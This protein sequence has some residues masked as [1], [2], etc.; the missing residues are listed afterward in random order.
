MNNDEQDDLTNPSGGIS[1]VS[2]VLFADSWRIHPYCPDSSEIK[3]S[4]NF[5]FLIILIV[6]LLLRLVE[7]L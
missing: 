6:K 7:M 1:E 5:Y 3:V 2:P 4:L